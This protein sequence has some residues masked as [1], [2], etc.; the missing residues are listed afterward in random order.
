VISRRV[1]PPEVFKHVFG[2]AIETVDPADMVEVLNVATGV[3]ILDK[4]AKSVPVI[5]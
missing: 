3:V 2:I 5:N 4:N 1:L